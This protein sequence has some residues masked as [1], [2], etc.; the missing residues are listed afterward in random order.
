MVLKSPEPSWATVNSNRLSVVCAEDK[1][2]VN[3]KNRV[4]MYFISFE[5]K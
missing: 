5:M 1:I 3:A 2:E 4:R